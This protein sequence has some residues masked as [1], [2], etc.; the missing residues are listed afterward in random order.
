MH[1]SPI[2]EQNFALWTFIIL[3]FCFY[4]VIRSIFK[5]VLEYLHSYTLHIQFKFYEIVFIGSGG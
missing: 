1:L 4:N 2:I 3:D 5:S